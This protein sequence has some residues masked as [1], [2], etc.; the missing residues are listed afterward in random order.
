MPTDSI[1][2][3]FNTTHGQL[4]CLYPF[5]GFGGTRAKR[6]S[7][8]WIYSNIK[9]LTKHQSLLSD[10]FQMLN[11]IADKMSMGLNLDK[12]GS[13]VEGFR[14]TTEHPQL[15]RKESQMLGTDYLAY[16]FSY[17]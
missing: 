13:A 1:H 8:L 5:F 11:A 6:L 16:T 2:L 12:L 17:Y 3:E 15:H 14:K 9:H 7:I 10:S 4:L